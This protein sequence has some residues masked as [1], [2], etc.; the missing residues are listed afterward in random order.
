MIGLLTMLVRWLYSLGLKKYV[1][2]FKR[3]E[4]NGSALL[5]DV[6]FKL[7]EQDFDMPKL[8]V[9]KILRNIEQLRLE[10]RISVLLAFLFEL[11][12]F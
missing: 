8:H 7:L 9:K 4:I 6:D 2:L 3:E 12:L 11:E 5:D 10:V 1:K